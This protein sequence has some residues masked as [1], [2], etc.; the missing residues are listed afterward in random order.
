MFPQFAT[1]NALTIATIMEMAA[2]DQTADFEF[3]RLHGMGET[4]YK[5]VT[6]GGDKIAC[7]I[8]AP[9]GGYRDLLA[10]LVRRLLEN[11]ANSS[12]VS[13]WSATSGS[14]CETSCVSPATS[15]MKARVTPETRK[16][17]C[18][19]TSTARTAR[20][21]RGLE[22]GDRKELAKL[23]ASLG[24]QKA[25]IEAKPLIP[26]PRRLPART[27]RGLASCRWQ[28]RRT[29]MKS[30]LSSKRTRRSRTRPFR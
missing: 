15:S 24:A 27:C 30:G 3:Q 25:E 8:Y 4:L 21:S 23:V 10:Y 13:R 11:G 26:A 1:H 17:R 20:N 9:V 16:S 28:A 22:F 18:H 6:E 2:P 14:R 7:R 5:S 12:F 19:A 29:V